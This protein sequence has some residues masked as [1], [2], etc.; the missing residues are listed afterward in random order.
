MPS[1]VVCTRTSAEPSRARNVASS[2]RNARTSPSDAKS[3]HSFSP[4]TRLRTPTLT[5]A[6]PARKR[7]QSTARAAPPAPRTT[8][9]APRRETPHAVKPAK[10]P[11][12]SVLYPVRHPS[13]PTTTVLTAPMRRASSSSAS[14]NAIISVLNGIVTLNPQNPASRSPGTALRRESFFTG[15]ATYT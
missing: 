1:G 12:A 15:S 4:L 7:P 6:T 13:A 14:S 11:A 9:C 10:N 8:A 5:C 3:A 2:K